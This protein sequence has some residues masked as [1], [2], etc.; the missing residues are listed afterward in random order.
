M[1]QLNIIATITVKPEFYDAFQPIFK[2]LVAGS[3]AE[4][5]CLRYEFNQSIDNSN[6][7]IVIE[8]WASQQAIDFHNTTSH[9]VEFANFAKEHTDRLEINIAKQVI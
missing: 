1:S 5:G 6:I 9:F 3:R 4:A 2:R 8:T 7:F